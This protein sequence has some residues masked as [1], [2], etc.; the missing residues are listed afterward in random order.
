[1][2]HERAIGYVSFDFKYRYLGSN[3]SARRLIPQLRFLVVDGEMGD[4]LGERK[5]RHFIDCF[6]ENPANH[7]FTYTVHPEN[8]PKA[9]EEAG[10]PAEVKAQA[11]RTAVA[12]P[13]D[14]RLEKSPEDGDRIYNVN[15]NYLYDGNRRHGYIVTFMDDTANRK[16]I[17]LLDSYNEKL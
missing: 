9:D 3:E 8:R 17:R 15:V 13:Q 7:L 1:M 14:D 16:Y 6:R 2:V 11:A 12:K 10:N 5:L 4:S